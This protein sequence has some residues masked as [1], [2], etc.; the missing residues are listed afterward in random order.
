MGLWAW[1]MGQLTQDGGPV[2]PDVRKTSAGG[3]ATLE[4]PSEPST[5]VTQE[6]GTRWWAPEG[7][8]LLDPVEACRPNL[9]T[10]AL[11]LESLLVSHF[12][13]HDLNMPPLVQAAERVLGR[14]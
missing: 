12:D 7:N 11:A 4:R 5:A 3:V 13:G 1:I 10:E 8:A 9:T 2:E 14:P 6:P